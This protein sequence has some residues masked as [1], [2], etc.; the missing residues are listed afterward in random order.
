ML[1]LSSTPEASSTDNYKIKF[2]SS[3]TILD[4][5]PQDVLDQGFWK[6]YKKW[7]KPLKKFLKSTFGQEYK[8]QKL[9]KRSL[10]FRFRD[11]ID[12]DLLISP[13]WSENPKTD[14]PD[15]DISVFHNT[16]I[17]NA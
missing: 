15:K 12:V 17:G 4:I 5:S 6:M 8:H 7:L 14:V 3:L 1:T 9:T 2:L 16:L 11:F 10:Q 13:F